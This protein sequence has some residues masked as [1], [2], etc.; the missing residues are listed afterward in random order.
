MI[1][2]NEDLDLDRAADITLDRIEIVTDQSDP[3]MVE[4]YIL[5]FKGDRIEGGKF[6]KGGL[7]TCILQ[8]YNANY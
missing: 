2:T 5:D 1:K 8:F 7:M 6:D 4:I 3:T